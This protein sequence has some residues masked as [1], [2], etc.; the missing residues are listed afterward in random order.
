MRFAAYGSLVDHRIR[1]AWLYNL[2]LDLENFSSV[3]QPLY[4]DPVTSNTIVRK[5]IANQLRAAARSELL[6]WTSLLINEDELYAE[7]GKA[8][9]ALEI[10]L[11]DNEYFFAS[12]RPGLFDASVFAYTHL[13]LDNHI[14]H[15]KNARLKAELETYD[16]LVQHRNRCLEVFYA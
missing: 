11:S 14:M 9:E 15:W 6:K 12:E 3:A 1:N 8:F 4:I 13:L 5:S 2:Y 10:L 16:R 7:A